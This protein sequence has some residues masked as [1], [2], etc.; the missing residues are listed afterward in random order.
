MF[1]ILSQSYPFS[2]KSKIQI[3]QQSIFEGLFVAF[4]LIV[5]QPFG[6]GNFTIENKYF[7]LL[8]YGVVTTVCVLLLRLIVFYRYSKYNEQSN[9]TVLKEIISIL[10]LISTITIGNY[11]LTILLFDIKINWTG[12]GNMFFMVFTIGLF[13]TVFGVMANYIYHFKKYNK[14]IDIQIV[15][16]VSDE[17]LSNKS[18]KII[19]ENG[20]D[21]IEIEAKNLYYIESSDNY[22]TLYFLKNDILQK[23]LIRSSLTRL[24]TQIQLNYIVRCHRSFIVNLENV[25]KVTGNAQG[26]KL[27]LNFSNLMVPV[28]RKY[29]ELVENLK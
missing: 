20:K 29:S 21:F 18:I 12:I 1:K 7:Y 19:A 16:N 22:S 25:Q 13:P 17:N 6:I 4:F 14:V 8:L 23:E 3:F 28:A 10:V 15:T 9:W 2:E 24:E 11:L 26:Y 27:H 5:I